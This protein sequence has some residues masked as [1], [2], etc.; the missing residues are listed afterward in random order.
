MKD[1]L[2]EQIDKQKKD[3]PK[4]K[5][6]MKEVEKYPFN[7]YQYVSFL[8]MIISFFCG[9]ILGNIFPSCQ[10]RGLYSTNCVV[11]EFNISL[12]IMT[13]FVSFIICMFIFWLGHVVNILN[14]INSKLRK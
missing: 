11:T 4:V 13:W 14:D 3:L 6:K 9:I 5:G 12:T 1:D 2:F 10:S 7:F 8:I